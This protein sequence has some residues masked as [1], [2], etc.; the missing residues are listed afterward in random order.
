MYIKIVHEQ[1]ANNNRDIEKRKYQNNTDI[2][3]KRIITQIFTVQI[4]VHNN[5]SKNNRNI[6]N[7]Y[8]NSTNVY[9]NMRRI[10]TEILKKGQIKITPK[11]Q[12]SEK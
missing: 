5:E 8:I 2:P 11:F 7:I 10:I 4:Y 1:E 3:I 6:Y 12:L 9:M